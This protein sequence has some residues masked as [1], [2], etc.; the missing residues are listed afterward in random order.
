MQHA[1]NSG[2]NK[3]SRGKKGRNEVKFRTLSNT[4][5]NHNGL[6]YMRHLKGTQSTLK[7]TIPVQNI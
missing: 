5:G 6:R 1:N 4:T 7:C 3:Q 2:S